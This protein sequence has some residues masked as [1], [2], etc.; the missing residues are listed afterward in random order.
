MEGLMK[1]FHRTFHAKEILKE[2]FRDGFGT[3]MTGMELTGV[4]VSDVPLDA[5]EGANGDVL[6][7]LEI[8]EETFADY[9]VVEEGKPY[10]EAIMPAKVLN[11][12]GPPIIEKG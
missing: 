6:L 2:G 8:P 7:S 12:F 9:E 4:W 11:S 5:N 1:V 10:R 3:Y